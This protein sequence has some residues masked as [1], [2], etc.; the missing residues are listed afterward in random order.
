VIITIKELKYFILAFSRLFVLGR[1]EDFTDDVQTP[2]DFLNGQSNNIRI[3]KN[4]SRYIK[5]V[6]LTGDDFS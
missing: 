4:A 3:S 2:F 1:L 6:P 5:F